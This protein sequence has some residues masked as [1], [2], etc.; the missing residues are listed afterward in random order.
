MGFH[1]SKKIRFIPSGQEGDEKPT[2]IWF[3]PMAAVDDMKLLKQFQEGADIEITSAGIAEVL[4]KKVIE[5]ENLDIDGEPIKTGEQLGNSDFIPF[6]L[7][8][9]I[10]EAIL[11][12]S[13]VS[14]EEK[15]A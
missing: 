13:G 6:G 12:S 3:T 4:K 15:K 9:E 7:K 11:K 5:I 8:N 14:Q 2:V 10:F 1:L